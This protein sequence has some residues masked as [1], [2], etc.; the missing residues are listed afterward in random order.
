M[1]YN[2]TSIKQLTN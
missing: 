1:S 2:E